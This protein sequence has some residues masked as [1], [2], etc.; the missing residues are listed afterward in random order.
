MVAFNDSHLVVNQVQ[1]DY[2]TKDLRMVNYVDKVKTMSMKITDFKICQIPREENKK[3]DALANLT[4]TF[5]FI[6]DRS[7]P[8]EFFLNP[9]IDVAKT[10]YQVV[11]VPTWMD[12][13]IAYLRD[14]NLPSNKLQVRRISTDQPD[15]TSSDGL[16]IRDLSL[17][18]S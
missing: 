17:A 12:D 4:S 9:S 8:L 6:S 13:I 15:S 18:H 5:D 7:L 14:G 1:G 2:L 16:C 11:A 10:I 3:T